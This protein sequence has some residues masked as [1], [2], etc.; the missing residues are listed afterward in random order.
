MHGTSQLG[1]LQR[2]PRDHPDRDDLR[3]WLAG[4]GLLTFHV[5]LFLSGIVVL[6]LINLATAP[7]DLWVEGVAWLWAVLLVIHALVVALLQLIALLRRD[8]RDGW[9]GDDISLSGVSRASARDGRESAPAAL[10]ATAGANGAAP[11]ANWPQPMSAPSPEPAAAAVPVAGT[12]SD[13][14]PA[15][16]TA[17]VDDNANEPWS[18]GTSVPTSDPPPSPPASERASWAEAGVGAWLSRRGQENARNA[19]PNGRA[20]PNGQPDRA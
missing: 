9:D 3:R 18:N 8:G 12:W 11:F 5:S 10:T 1:P 16:G 6:F 13:W 4:R 2:S 15:T 19:P 7:A 17:T 14:V 20:A